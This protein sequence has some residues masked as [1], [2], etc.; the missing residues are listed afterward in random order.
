MLERAG[1]TEAEIVVPGTAADEAARGDDAGT[2]AACTTLCGRK[3]AEASEAATI[4][5]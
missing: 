1:H 3:Q 5:Y 2:M 4:I